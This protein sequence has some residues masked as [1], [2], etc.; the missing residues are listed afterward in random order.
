MATANEI[1]NFNFP[2]VSLQEAAKNIFQETNIQL[3]ELRINKL[4]KI[5]EKIGESSFKF[6]NELIDAQVYRKFSTAIS[7]NKYQIINLN[8]FDK[9]ELKALSK[10]LDY[11]EPNNPFTIIASENNVSIALSTLDKDWK[12][13]FLFGLIRCYLKNWESRHN[14]SLK[15][16]YEFILPK[17]NQYNG[18]IAVLKSFQTNI[19]FFDINNGDVV[20]GYELAIKNKDIKEVTKH[21]SLPEN[22]VSYP[23]FSKVIVAYYEKQ[24]IKL[25]HL[26]D[27]IT[28]AL[29]DHNSSITN[30]RLVS[31]LIIQANTND[32]AALQDKVKNIAFKLVGD[33]E[34]I[35]N[36][37]A[38]ENATETE[39]EEL[40]KARI[41]L[42]EWITRQFINVFFEKCINDRR[43][44]KFWLKYVSKISSFVVYGSKNVKTLLKSDERIQDIVEARFKTVYSNKGVSAFI[45]YLADYVLIEFSDEG[46]AFYAY[47]VNGS[48]MPDLHQRQNSVDDLRNGTMPMLATRKYQNIIEHNSEGRLSH[49]DGSHED[50]SSLHW[51]QVFDWWIKKYTGID[52]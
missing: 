14:N 50:G 33:P 18:R 23:Y 51:E 26:L 27:N 39:K 46:Y 16:I 34:N 35:T 20:F 19:K 40:K 5:T 13:I 10:C 30:K 28:T 29:T 48:F 37:L 41:I 47:K 1:L 4:L 12:D 49:K 38:F 15:R 43:R 8:G 21:L 36:W 22:W 2:H 31:K 32:L 24:K 45:I 52:V 25:P 17:L 42:N 44:K 9:K 7:N 3:L 11:S 6:E